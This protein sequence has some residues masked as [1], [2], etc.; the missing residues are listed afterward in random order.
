MNKYHIIKNRIHHSLIG[1]YCPYGKC[2]AVTIL[3][4]VNVL[5]LLI[6]GSGPPFQVAVAPFK[7]CKNQA[8]A[9]QALQD[10]D[11][12]TYLYSISFHNRKYDSLMPMAY[13]T[14]AFN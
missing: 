1:W 10:I 6:H 3:V 14:I 2:A 5:W 9:C 7:Q 4:I 11:S 8:T 13:D 12:W